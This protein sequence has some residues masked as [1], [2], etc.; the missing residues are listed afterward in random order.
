MYSNKLRLIIKM[1]LFSLLVFVT[2]WLQ[3]A[4]AQ[5]MQTPVP[6]NPALQAAPRSIED[7][8]LR[9]LQQIAELQRLT[10]QGSA[11]VSPPSGV[12]I[13]QQSAA[14]QAV[15][16]PQKQVVIL[17]EEDP[18]RQQAYEEMLQENNPLTPEQIRFLREMHDKTV[19]AS[20]E[21][22]NPPRPTATSQYVRLDPGTTP[23]IIRLAQGFVTSLVFLDSTGAPWPILAYD[24]GDPGAFNVQWNRKDNILIVQSKVFKTYGNMAV[25]LQG[26]TTP[27]MLTLIPGQAAVDYRVDLR[28]QGF[29]PNAK[30]LPFGDGLPAKESAMLLDV[31]D[32]IPPKGSNSLL[33]SGA[34]GVQAWSA[35][36]TMYVR[37]RHNILSPGWVSSLQSADGMHAYEMKKTSMI[38]VAQNGQIRKVKIEG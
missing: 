2:Q 37:T 17:G 33:V 36:H 25:R 19:T 22:V 21:N 35:G 38:L 9:Q 15:A 32:G 23:P 13:Q 14:G 31:L 27:I 6:A 24:I 8:N 34:D 26:L 4:T 3:A 20:E 16:K 5:D 1:A 28:V 18:L 12:N 7:E 10:N 29:G 30:V 11:L